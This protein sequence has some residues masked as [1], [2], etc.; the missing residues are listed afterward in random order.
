MPVVFDAY[1]IRPT[2]RDAGLGIAPV[3]RQTVEDWRTENGIVSRFIPLH[4]PG[5][6]GY[7]D[8]FHPL[9]NR[10]IEHFENQGIRHGQLCRVTYYERPQRV[11]GRVQMQMWFDHVDPL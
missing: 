7:L 1:Y 10:Q 4:D 5:G 9:T 2:G 11:S 3:S 8:S 6:N